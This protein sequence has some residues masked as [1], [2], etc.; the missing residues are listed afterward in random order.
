MY[1]ASGASEIRYE[2]TTL[3]S[4]ERYQK[5]RTTDY[6][7]DCVF[8]KNT[9]VFIDPKIVRALGLWIFGNDQLF[10]FHSPFVIG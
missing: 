5:T 8:F 7:L 2:T 3:S 4:T 9:L 1:A 6:N 10:T